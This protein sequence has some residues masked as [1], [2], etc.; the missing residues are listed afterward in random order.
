MGTG[1]I[2]LLQAAVLGLAVFTSPALAEG[3]VTLG[4]GR[5]FSN[6]ATGD[7]QDRWRTGAYAISRVKGT[8]W[9]D[10]LPVRAGDILEFRLRAET[11]AP[12]NLIAPAAG[13]RRYVGALSLGL[14]THFD[15]RSHEVSLGGDLVFTGPQTGIGGFQKWAH[16]QLGLAAPQVLGNQLPNAVYPTLVGEIGHSYDLSSTLRLRPFGELRVGAETLVRLGGDLVFGK[17]GRNDLMLRDATTGQRYRGV[18][19]SRN[20]GFSLTL[21]ADIAQVLSSAFLPS[22]GAADLRGQRARARAGVHWQGKTAS[23]FYGITYLS[24]EFDQQAEGQAVGSLS[25]K[26]RF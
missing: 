18:E 13:D 6:D 21:G 26:I 25:I 20:R 2:R 16:K 11:I 8:S 4:W 19:G 14:H 10:A 1:M 12:A 3:R 7:G 15:W 22:G 9:A 5:L 23:G 17:F 24:R